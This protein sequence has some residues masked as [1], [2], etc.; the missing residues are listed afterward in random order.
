MIVVKHDEG[1]FETCFLHPKKT[2]NKIH[3]SLTRNDLTCTGNSV[4]GWSNFDTNY[5]QNSASG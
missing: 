1:L 3:K 2:Y 5:Y 4:L